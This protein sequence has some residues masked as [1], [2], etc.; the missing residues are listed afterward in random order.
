MVDTEEATAAESGPRVRVAAII[1]KDGAI[2]LA[3]HQKEGETYYVLPGGGVDFGETCEEAL[4]RELKEEANLD[5]RVGQLVIVNDSVPPDRHRHVLNLHFTAAVV[6]GEL[7]VGREPRLAG[8]EFVSFEDFP[9][10]T[11]YPD[12]RAALL[13]AIRDGFPDHAVYL[14]NLWVDG[15]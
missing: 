7:R 12:V 6:S 11:L 9:S 13:P 4:V 8:M 1:L 15:T 5:I 14:G 10:V 2:L 3:R